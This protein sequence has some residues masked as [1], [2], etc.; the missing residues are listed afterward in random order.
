MTTIMEMKGGV[1]IVEP[2]GKIIGTAAAAELKEK[3]ISHINVS[4]VPAILVNFDHVSKIDSAG[5]GALVSVY[6][7]ARQKKV[8][9]GIIN[10][11]KH[12][13]SLVVQSRLINIFEHFENEDA[14]VASLSD[15][16]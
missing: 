3:L 7:L 9:I 12:I 16:T 13:R 6:I 5:L 4:D 15:H 11:G 10:I 8:R 2:D 14:A 1:P